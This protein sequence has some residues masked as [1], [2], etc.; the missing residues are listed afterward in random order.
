MNDKDLKLHLLYV[1]S[2]MLGY[3]RYGV[4]LADRL[5]RMGVTVRDSIEPDMTDPYNVVCWVSTPTH[6]RGWFKG[7]YPVISTMWEATKLPETFRECLHNFEMVIVPSEQNQELFSRY[8]HNVKYVPLGIETARWFYTPRTQPEREFR[9]LIGG[10]GPRKGT[11][12]AYKA[13]RKLWPT[14]GS[15]GSGPIPTLMFKSPR[16][17]D[18]M[19]PRIHHIGGFIPSEQEVSLYE[20]AH[21]YLQPSRGEGFGLQPLQAIAQGLPTILTDAHGHHGFAHL[22]RPISA[23]MKK[24]DYFIFGDAGDWWEPNLDELCDQMK[25]V[26]DHY[27]LACYEAKVSSR[28]AA[29]EWGWERTAE[30]FIDAVGVDKLAAPY[31]PSV[32]VPQN[33]PD[34]MAAPEWFVPEQKLYE[35]KVNREWPCNIGG[36]AYH[37]RPKYADGTTS[38]WELADVKRILFENGVLDPV[39]VEFSNDG[40]AGEAET[41]L[42]KSQLE[43][44]PAYSAS[45]KHCIYCGQVLNSG[46]LWEPEYEEAWEPTPV[47]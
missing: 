18:W 4:K 13:F 42:T 38:T 37:F 28:I 30:K 1:H 12:L 2:E 41:G 3:A 17:I 8:H 35:V 43:R 27:D 39:C 9:F 21:C 34:H 15:W 20:A 45:H 23:T 5:Q 19:G 46:E 11:D 29:R 31:K 16:A 22:G 14:E 6:A 24:S 36:I 32:W 33:M 47:S 7:Q 26:Y 10:S 44:V 40:E 25:W